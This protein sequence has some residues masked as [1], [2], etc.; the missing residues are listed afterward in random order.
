MK[1]AGEFEII[2]REAHWDEDTQEW[3]AGDIIET[4]IQPNQVRSWYSYMLQR[5]DTTLDPAAYNVAISSA[6]VKTFGDYVYWLAQGT[7]INNGAYTARNPVDPREPAITLGYWTW[8][9]RFDPPGSG[10]RDI[11]TIQLRYTGTSTNNI[12]QQIASAGLSEICV[13]TDSQIIDIFYRMYVDDEAVTSAVTTDVTDTARYEQARNIMWGA[14]TPGSKTNYFPTHVGFDWWPANRNIDSTGSIMI[15]NSALWVLTN[16]DSVSEMQDGMRDDTIAMVTTDYIGYLFGSGTTNNQLCNVE[17][18][19]TFSQNRLT[20]NT[21]LPTG[22]SRMQ[23][24]FGKLK[25][26]TVAWLDID[27]QAAGTGSISVTESVP[28][29]SWVK[30]T[31]TDF[32]QLY[33]LLITTSGDVGTS[34]YK[35]LV[36]TVPPLGGTPWTCNA[37]IGVPNLFG[38]RDTNY[39]ARETITKADGRGEMIRHGLCDTFVA[40]QLNP[41]NGDMM[42]ENAPFIREY[43]YPEFMSVGNSFGDRYDAAQYDDVMG[44]TLYDMK[45]RFL[46]VNKFN[47]PAF[48]P[49]NIRQ[50]AHEDDSTIWVACSDTGLWKIVRATSGSPATVDDLSNGTAAISSITRITTTTGVADNTICRGVVAEKTDGVAQAGA[51]VWAIFDKEMCWTNDGGATWTTYNALSTPAFIITGVTGG[52]DDASGIMHFE[53]DH[54]HATKDRFFL[55]VRAVTATTDGQGYWWSTD[56]T[57]T[58]GGT[59]IFVDVDATAPSPATFVTH[60][61]IGTKCVYAGS[62]GNWYFASN[63][64]ITGITKYAFNAT[65]DSGEQE[66]TSISNRVGVGI[67]VYFDENGDDWIVGFDQSGNNDTNVRGKRPANVLSTSITGSKVLC[68]RIA[69]QS[70]TIYD[71]F[72]LGLTAYVGKGFW[73]SLQDG[74]NWTQQSAAS[75]MNWCY[76]RF[77]ENRDG[78]MASDGSITDDRIW[79][80]YGWNGSAWIEGNANSRVT[81]STTEDLYD[82]LEVSFTT[83]SNLATS[84]LDT[85]MYDAYAFDGII[86]DNATTLS[87]NYHVSTFPTVT[88][89]DFVTTT[90]PA[91]PVGLV[92]NELLTNGYADTGDLEYEPGIMCYRDWNTGNTA[93]YAQCEQRFV[94]DFSIEF[95]INQPYTDAT[96]L[97]KYG[98]LDISLANTETQNFVGGWI[99]I[100]NAFSSPAGTTNRYRIGDGSNTTEDASVDIVTQKTNSA[101][102]D[103]FLKDVTFKVERVGTTI[104]WYWRRPNGSYTLIHSKA[105]VSNELVWGTYQS[106]GYM[107]S[108]FNGRCTYTP[109]TYHTYIGND[110]TTG[111]GDHTGTLS[112]ADDTTVDTSDFP[113]PNFKGVTKSIGGSYNFMIEV[114]TTGAGNW[115]ERDITTYPYDTLANTEV[116][117]LR[118]G[119][120]EFHA[121]DAGRTFRGNWIYTQ[122]QNLT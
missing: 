67:N 45:S 119:K 36:A 43:V 93:D 97:P 22:T 69:N 66:S 25:T 116:R 100:D 68:W 16:P 11:A 89:T 14:A 59:A 104:S 18:S 53:K 92:T 88:G 32:A 78:G 42:D 26:S 80:E 72:L 20:N 74:I 82:G 40:T 107:I 10:Q 31:D 8:R 73:I 113:D 87:Y 111:P 118:S 12:F 70:G 83:D 49:T 99:L 106:A 84:F 103:Y 3:I 115:V 41:A 35:L 58:P 71:N 122:R 117:I 60:E 86:K 63:T 15:Q 30:Q 108:L 120:V 51:I 21:L 7:V 33:R 5:N 27:N 28:G 38:N 91:A 48:V 44:L 85:D 39:W 54:H 76:F 65:N 1:I 79:T 9:A 102:D 105:G 90:V 94:G 110:T 98:L 4:I 47:F 37:L 29:S 121:D 55:A 64:S 50:V 57:D 62:D 101:L 52:G 81:H 23:S 109:N 17:G 114:D 6:R 46:N 77:Y 56:G 112:G 75:T 61:R 13:Q 2:K 95:C 34:E 24:T 19:S 96:T